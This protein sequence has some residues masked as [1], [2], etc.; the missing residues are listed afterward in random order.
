MPKVEFEIGEDGTIGTLPEPLQKFLDK[1]INDAHTRAY[2][3]AAEE[4]RRQVGDPVDREKLRQLEDEKK[5]RE[6]ADLERDKQY[7]AAAKLRDEKWQGE[8][9][10]RDQEIQRRDS[11]LRDSLRAEIRAAAVRA[12]ARDESLAELEAILSGRLDLN[13]D[14]QP[15]VKGDDGQ[16]AIDKK[17]GAP[18]SIEGL[19]SGYLDTHQHHRAAPAGTGGGARGGASFASGSGTDAAARLASAK[20]K[21]QRG[22]RSPAVMQDFREAQRELQATG[23]GA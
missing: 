5:A 15:F 12:G 14:L 10:K 3:K 13:P 21:L 1:K 8:L 2:S 18:V 19:V 20:E 23:K 4:A 22:D 17:T 16:P 6:I 9:Q 11:R 7:D